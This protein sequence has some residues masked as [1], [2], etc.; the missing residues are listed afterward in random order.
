M[1]Y[2]Q[3]EHKHEEGPAEHGKAEEH[4]E[5]EGEEGA[6]NVGPDKGII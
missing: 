2:A 4:H 6:K 5:E 3:D 1:L